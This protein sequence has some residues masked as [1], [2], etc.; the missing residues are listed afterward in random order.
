MT[1]NVCYRGMNRLNVDAA[2]ATLMTLRRHW[3]R[4]IRSPKGLSPVTSGAIGYTATAS[5]F[6][7]L[8]STNKLGCY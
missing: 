5:I 6:C 8:T 4:I 2:K 1:A 3:R 7:I